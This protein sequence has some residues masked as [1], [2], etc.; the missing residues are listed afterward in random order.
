MRSPHANGSSSPTAPGSPEPLVSVLLPSYQH[1]RFLPEC[2]ASVLEEREIPLELVV[3]DDGSTDGSAEILAEAASRDPRLRL[4]VQENRGA[5]AAFERA[6]ADSRGEILLLL[7]SDDAYAPGRIRR[8]VELLRRRPEVGMVASWVEVVD[9]AGERLGIKEAWRTLEPWPRPGRPGLAELGD[10]ALALLETNWMATTSNLAVRRSA[11]EGIPIQALRYTHD[12]DLFLALAQRTELA[13][14]P[15]PLVRYR[16]HD[17]NTIREG[18][19]DGEGRMRFEILW[20]VARHAAPLLRRSAGRTGS[21]LDHLQARFLRSAPRFGRRD[22][23]DL[24]LVARGIGESPPSAY[25]ALLHE[26]DPFRARAIELLG[27]SS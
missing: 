21:D 24:L 3:V 19:E 15:E 14:V 6:L 22:L 17:D 16:V 5:H 25:D 9:A 27:R 4:R 7:N 10:P 23:L 18:R 11:L 2:L 1:A 20:T 13:L 26:G 12:W 8:V